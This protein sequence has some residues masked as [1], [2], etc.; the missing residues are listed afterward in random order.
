MPVAAVIRPALVMPPLDMPPRNVGPLIE[1]ALPVDASIAPWA[2]IRMPSAVPS[3]RPLS[4]IEPW[5]VPLPIAMAVAAEIVPELLILP[6]KVET[7]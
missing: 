7:G 3:M 1:M 2:S 6:L 4:I 5:M